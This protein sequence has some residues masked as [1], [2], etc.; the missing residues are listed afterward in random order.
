MQ[1]KK[2]LKK[3]NQLIEIK[4]KLS[5]TQMKMYNSILFEVHKKLQIAKDRQSEFIFNYKELKTLS[6]VK[7]TSDTRIRQEIKKIKSIE[8]EFTDDKKGDWGG[9]NL[10][11]AYKKSG[12]DIILEIPNM[13]QDSLIK[14]N[15]YTQLDFIVLGTFESKYS[16]LLYEIINKYKG[17]HIKIPKYS[18]EEFKSVMGTKN[19]KSYNNFGLLRKKVIDVAVNEINE[20]TDLSVSYKEIK[21]G[22]K[23]EWLQFELDKEDKIQKVTI[24]GKE[25][26]IEDAKAK[27]KKNIYVSKAWNKRVDNKIDRIIN[28]YS[29]DYAIEILNA[30]YKNLKE[31]IKTSL[32][33]YING[34]IKNMEYTPKELPLKAIKEDS[35]VVPEIVEKELDLSKIKPASKLKDTSSKIKD[36]IYVTKEEFEKKVV[37]YMRESNINR[38]IAEKFLKIRYVVMD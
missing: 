8:I 24:E 38:K 1:L 19:S 31:D 36:K 17:E 37:E 9:F 26:L 4:G 14:H 21:K 29:K 32:V 30:I 16:I 15:Y 11:S 22:K 10:I 20:K 34:V 35:A 5:I 18:I 6:G 2:I 12:E 13:I 7:T 27:A 23:V 3:P 33:Q 25:T 28:T